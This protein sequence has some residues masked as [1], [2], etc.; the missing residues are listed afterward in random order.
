[1]IRA[2]GGE[3]V[4]FHLE[5]SKGWSL[6]NGEL[7]RAY[8]EAKSKG[9]NPKAI[10]IINPGNPTGSVLSKQN[11]QDVIKF[12]YEHNLALLADEVYQDNI[13]NPAKPFISCK[14]VMFEMGS[15]YKEN[16]ELISFHSVSKGVTGDCGLRGGYFEFLN[17]DPFAAEM[18]LK[19]KSTSLTPNSIGMLNMGLMV[20][21][22][23]AGINS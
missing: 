23:R 20:N 5:E 14:K 3:M 13:Y 8:K 21:P 12:A 6:E 4:N 17:I 15:P 7:E 19:L 11:I 10:T 9:I 16:V 1:M 2:Y 18:L 22:P